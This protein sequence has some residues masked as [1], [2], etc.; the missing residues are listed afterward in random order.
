MSSTQIWCA[1][2]CFF[3]F[4]EIR[5]SKTLADYQSEGSTSIRASLAV[6]PTRPPIGLF[7][8]W[9]TL[10]GPAVPP[11]SRFRPSIRRAYL[12]F[13]PGRASTEGITRPTKITAWR[14]PGVKLDVQGKDSKE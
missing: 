9:M 6:S 14:G 5:W 11:V 12:V 10:F 1:L 8:I 4:I 7:F 2:W 13:G 3:F